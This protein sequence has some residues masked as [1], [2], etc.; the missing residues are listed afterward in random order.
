MTVRRPTPAG[1]AGRLRARAEERLR[2]RQEGTPPHTE[3][4]ALRL[5]QELQVHQI[6]LEIQNAELEKTRGELE[7]SLARYTDLYDFAPIGYFTLGLDGSV[8]SANLTG[9]DLLGV[10]RARLLGRR[11]GEFA[12][13]ESRPGLASFLARTLES[14]R[15]ETCELT[16]VTQGGLRRIVRLEATASPAGRECRA[17][18]LDVTEQ[19]AAE[20]LRRESEEH[21]RR[22]I[23]DNPVPIMIHDEDDRVLQ[24][25]SGWTHCSGY[26]LDDLPTL[27]DWTER[28]YGS[29]TGLEKATIDKLFSIDQT[30]RNGEWVVTAKDGGKRIWDFQTTPLGKTGAGR[31]V[32]LSLAVDVTERKAAEEEVRRVNEGL[33]AAVRKRTAELQAANSEL[34]AFAHSVSHDLRAPLRAIS[35]F[36]QALSEDCAGRLPPTGEDYIRRIR[37]GAQRMGVLIDDLLRLSRTGR[38]GLA[39]TDLDLAVPCREIL[40]EL[41][42]GSPERH[43]ETVVA[44]SLLVHGDAHLL[45]QLLENLLGNAWKFTAATAGARIEVGAEAGTDGWQELF[46]RDNGAGFDPAYVGKLFRPFQRLHPESVFA[47]TGIGLAIVDRIARYHGGTVGAEGEVGRGATFRVRLPA[48]ENARP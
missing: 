45:R 37:G 22:A 6:E 3:V 4:D 8:F 12:A 10:P 30:V 9:A 2:I 36:S 19:R 40:A 46:V 42:S 41:A 29:R 18:V 5:L 1:E 35:G 39:R 16:L 13:P 48:P 43:V 14:A 38:S 47:G 26:T 17:A 15:P 11:F 28:A 20:A 34:E 32:L 33:E 21:F 44:E 27:A 23:A 7:S 31:R 24:L 25:S